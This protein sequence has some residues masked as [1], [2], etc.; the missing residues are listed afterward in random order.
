MRQ[1]NWLKVFSLLVYVCL[2]FQK[3]VLNI[4][5]HQRH[6]H[7]HHFYRSQHGL[8]VVLNSCSYKL[9]LAGINARVPEPE[10]VLRSVI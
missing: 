8:V 7:Y 6:H 4:S 10:P 2:N 5:N 9:F 3:L 1:R